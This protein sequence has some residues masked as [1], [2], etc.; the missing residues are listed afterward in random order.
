MYNSDIPGTK[1]VIPG[2]IT[3]RRMWKPQPHWLDADW[4]TLINPARGESCPSGQRQGSAAPGEDMVSP[5]DHKSFHISTTP[6]TWGR[7]RRSPGAIPPRT[8]WKPQPHRLVTD[9]LGLIE[10]ARGESCP[11]G[12]RRGRRTREGLGLIPGLEILT[13]LYNS[14]NLGTEA[15]IPRVIPPRTVWKPQPHLLVADW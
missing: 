13:Y 2:S 11:S 12:Q 15:E 3:S 4:R 10:P 1:T 5:T 7:K 8:V 14:N 6:T 9:W